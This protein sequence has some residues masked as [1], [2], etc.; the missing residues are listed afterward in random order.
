M[1]YPTDSL[2]LS[3]WG[4]AFS[5]PLAV[6]VPFPSLR[7]VRSSDHR[8]RGRGLLTTVQRRGQKTSRNN[9]GRRCRDDNDKEAAAKKATVLPKVER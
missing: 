8:P 3:F 4:V 9:A 2:F 1:L 6:I 5:T 7:R